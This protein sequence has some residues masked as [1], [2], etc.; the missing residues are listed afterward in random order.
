MQQIPRASED[1]SA[2]AYAF[3]AHQ[4]GE[5]SRQEYLTVNAQLSAD[6]LGQFRPQ[7]YLPLSQTLQAYVH[8]RL[9]RS[10]DRDVDLG[11]RLGH[12]I[13]GT[14][15]ARGEN[16]HAVWHLTWAIEQLELVKLS[17]HVQRV[18]AAIEEFTKLAFPFELYAAAVAVQEID[19]NDRQRG[20][21]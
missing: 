1:S 7:P 13:S 10:R 11:I 5:I 6:K 18:R 15:R 20:R 12:W 16:E 9:D 3:F 19:S 8:A 17:N 21:A 4:R 14:L 2:E